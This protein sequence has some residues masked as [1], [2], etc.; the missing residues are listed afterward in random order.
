MFSNIHGQIG[1]I[2]SHLDE[3]EKAYSYRHQAISF[4]ESN[5]LNWINLATLELKVGKGDS[6]M[7]ICERIL[8]YDPTHERAIELKGDLHHSCGQLEQ[9]FMYYKKAIEV[10]P[11]SHSAMSSMGDILLRH[12][13][14]LKEAIE[15]YKKA[16][17]VRVDLVGTFS[18]LC[19][20]K[21]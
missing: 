17:S 4:D 16:L 18:K 12:G 20:A 13:G 21:M 2:Y 19:Y 15:H 5:V 9:A 14:K 3:N 10:N 7:Q 11:E 8:S 1:M 6:C